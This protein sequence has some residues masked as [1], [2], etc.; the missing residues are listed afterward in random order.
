M[1]F[2]VINHFLN[3][4]MIACHQYYWCLL[5]LNHKINKNQLAGK[6]DCR[7]GFIGDDLINDEK[8]DLV[9]SNSVLH[10]IKQT[11][12]FWRLIKKATKE[13]GKFFIMDLLRPNSVDAAAALVEQYASDESGQLKEDFYNSLL[14]AYNLNEIEEQLQENSIL[15]F[16][17]QQITDRHFI[18]FGSM[19]A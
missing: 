8:F 5:L 10:H 2:Q 11:Q 4:Q 9:V 15:D 14:A 17:I 19:F 13:G 18:V 1:L 6:I 16:N 3:Y 7:H 12:S